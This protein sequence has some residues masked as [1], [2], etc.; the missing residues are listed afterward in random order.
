MDE[1]KVSF[2]TK[3]QIRYEGVLVNIERGEG[4][5]TLSE[6]HAFGTEGRRN[7]QD[8]IPPS[9][10][11]FK[12]VRFKLNQIEDLKSSDGAPLPPSFQMGAL[13][14]HDPAVVG[15]SAHA[16]ATREDD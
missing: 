14:V 8:E 7:G 4:T 12:C 11:I 6:V 3:S 15:A 13:V 10:E 9:T 5:I 16:P 1:V 2:V